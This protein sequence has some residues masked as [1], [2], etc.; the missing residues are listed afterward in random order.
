[1]KLRWEVIVCAP[2]V[3]SVQTLEMLADDADSAASSAFMSNDWLA[4]FKL[5]A[6]VAPDGVVF[7]RDD[8]RA[9]E[10]GVQ[11]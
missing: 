3:T 6:V 8:N 2:D 11:L 5:V 10:Y 7:V 9:E 4:D 1:M